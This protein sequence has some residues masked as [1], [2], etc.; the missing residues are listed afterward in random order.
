M[1]SVRGVACLIL[2][3]LQ[4]APNAQVIFTKHAI[5]LNFQGACSVSSSDINHDGLP[6]ILGAASGANELAWWENDGS[7]P[8]QFTKHVIDETFQTAIYISSGDIDADGDEDVLGAAWDGNQVALWLNN[9]DHPVTWTKEIIEEG[10]TQAHEVKCANIDGVGGIDIVAASAGKN[11]VAWWQNAGGNPILWNKYPLPQPVNGARSVCPVDIDADGD[12]DL[13]C[14]A[15]SSNKVILFRNDGGNPLEWTWQTVSSSFG[16]AHWMHACDMDNDGVLDLLGASC[17]PGSIAIW[18][19]QGGNPI[20]WEQQTLVPGLAGALSVVADDLDGNGYADVIAAGVN[21]G[22]V[23]LWFNQGG[24]PPTFSKYTLESSFP[25]AWPVHVCDL[26]NDLEPDIIS[27]SSSLNDIYWWDNQMIPTREDEFSQ[28]ATHRN[29]LSAYPNPFS[30]Q[31]EI[32]FTG[33]DGTR[34]IVQIVSLCGSLIR[35]LSE[36]EGERDA[37]CFPWDGCDEAGNPVSKGPYLCILK[38]ED[39]IIDRNIVIRY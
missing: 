38:T 37:V 21:A 16:G 7:S 6:D 25:G 33:E 22:D 32:R 30:E 14:A 34:F 18:Y 3:I 1:T 36:E 26:E 19:N 35:T 12:M 27:A 39:S 29:R 9:G 11:E 15:F 24:S 13:A 20:Q 10:F 5:D 28:P 23:I 4:Q 17:I 8:P 2:C 31:T